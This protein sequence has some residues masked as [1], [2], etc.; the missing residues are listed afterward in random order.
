MV[1]APTKANNYSKTAFNQLWQ[2]L[3]NSQ[4]KAAVKREDEADNVFAGFGEGKKTFEKTGGND[5]FSNA[6]DYLIKEDK[7]ALTGTSARVLDFIVDKLPMLTAKIAAFGNFTG[8]VLELFPFS[9]SLISKI[10]KITTWATQLSFIPYGIKG[11]VNGLKKNNFYQAIAFVGE[12]IF[13]FLGDLKDIYLLRGLPTGVDQLPVATEQVTKEKYGTKF[14][15]MATGLVEVPKVMWQQMVEI[16]KNPIQ[17][18]FFENKG[19]S[20]LISSLGSMLAS[21]G[22]MLTKNEKLFGP[23][24]DISAF[25]IDWEMIRHERPR[26]RKAGWLFVME[27]VLDFVAR[28]AGRFRLFFNQL[29]HGCG[30]L[31]LQ[32]YLEDYDDAIREEKEAEAKKAAMEGARV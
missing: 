28:Y 12:P 29:S 25:F 4:E 26:L 7:K 1:A 27:E 6:Y 31:A 3:A 22:Y 24:R 2:N 8:G 14:P 21:V 19:H 23:I 16:I 20:A 17:K 32:N 5:W 30:R 15:S 18:I 11:I 10:E 9:K 13:A